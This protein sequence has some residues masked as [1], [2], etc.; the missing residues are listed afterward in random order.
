MSEEVIKRALLL[1]PCPPYM[2]LVDYL[3]GAHIVPA[4]VLR[5]I[6]LRDGRIIVELL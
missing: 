5:A 6:R 3:F 2:R 1:N 4:M